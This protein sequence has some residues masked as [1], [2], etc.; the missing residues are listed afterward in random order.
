M[1]ENE[2]K[3]LNLLGLARRAGKLYAGQDKVIDGCRKGKL[4]VI[5]TN[6]C[7]A[8]VLRALNGSKCVCL[9]CNRTELGQSVGLK[10]AQVAALDVNNGFVEKILSLANRSDVNE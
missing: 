4:L 5:M 7:S 1:T 2:K 9:D 3:I 6:D 8:N 10:T